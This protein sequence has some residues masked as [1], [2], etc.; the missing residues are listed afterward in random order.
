[1]YHVDTGFTN[2]AVPLNDEVGGPLLRAAARHG[3]LRRHRL[4]RKP[5]VQAAMQS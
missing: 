4:R 5:H 3:M 1:M 2:E